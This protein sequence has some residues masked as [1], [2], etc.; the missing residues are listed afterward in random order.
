MSSIAL[1]FQNHNLPII[2]EPNK[3]PSNEILVPKPEVQTISKY[4]LKSHAFNK[5]DEAEAWLNKKIPKLGVQR[6]YDNVCEWIETGTQAQA[7][8]LREFNKWVE[9]LGQGPWYEKLGIFL[10]K[11]PIKVARNIWS[12]VVN[13][14]KLAISTPTYFLIHPMKF[15]LKLAKILIE[16]MQPE[17]WT[18]IGGGLM[19]SSAATAAVTGGFSAVTFAIGAALAFAGISVGTLKTVL[20]AEKGM[21]MQA[22]EEYLGRQALQLTESFTTSLCLVFTLEGIQQVIRGIQKL[23]NYCKNKS[24]IS[25]SKQAH[26]HN[27]SQEYLQNHPD[28]PKGYSL[29]HNDNYFTLK[30]NANKFPDG[31]PSIDGATYNGVTQVWT[32]TETS[33]SWVTRWTSDGYVTEYVTTSTPIYEPFYVYRVGLQG[34]TAPARIPLG[35]APRIS[36]EVM[37]NLGAVETTTAYNTERST[38]HALGALRGIGKGLTTSAEIYAMALTGQ[39]YR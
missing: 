23:D 20:I 10:A 6:V 11:L 21:K 5:I 31:A 7:A 16:L 22:G 2:N 35:A 24:A 29:S 18:K 30:W 27:Q 4:D 26:I 14:I 1:D 9:D 32:R 39:R 19:G 37:A 38:V 8:E 13:F 17:T 25:S 3:N 36:S 34:W 28:L 12:L 15:F 33:S